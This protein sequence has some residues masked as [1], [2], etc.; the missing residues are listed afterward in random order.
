MK[1]NLSKKIISLLLVIMML[2]S[3]ISLMAYGVSIDKNDY[4]VV[5]VH[6]FMASS[7]V[8][9]KDDPNS[10]KYFPI[11]TKQIV[12]GVMLAVPALG[13][14]VLKQDWDA[15]G[16]AISPVLEKIFDGVYNNPDGSANGNSG[17]Y[18]EYPTEQEVKDS[19]IVKF[20]YDWRADP[21]DIASQLNDFVKYVKKASGK[22]KVYLSCHSLGGVIV[23]SYLSLYGNEDVSGVAFDATAIYGESYTGDLLTGKIDIESQSLLYSI[24]NSLRGSEVEEM[25]NSLLE[26]FE[27]AGLFKLVA[28]LGNEL[29]VRLRGY[30][31]EALAP[32]FASWLTIWAMVPDEMMDDAIDFVFGEI[33]DKNDKEASELLSKVENYNTLIRSHKTETLKELDKTANVVVISRYGFSSIPVTPSWNTLS[34]T[35]VDTKNNSFGATTAPYGESFS[36][37]YLK[38]KDMKYISPDKTVDASTCLFPDKTWFIRN[39]P[40][41]E[42]CDELDTM[43]Y[44]LLKSK[45]EAT[46][47]AYKEYPRFMQ[48]IAATESV[49]PDVESVELVALPD[50][51]VERLIKLFKSIVTLL[52]NTV[53]GL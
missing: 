39:I 12:S 11:D 20:S 16:E 47:D 9:D 37:E 2:L 23:L 29:A 13:K 6:G 17:H 33:Y 50:G 46:V 34:D 48:Y 8:A 3:T 32:L 42:T 26:V 15:F 51:F 21:V 4:P 22:D 41:A 38:D 49:C 25:V 31:Y 52:V 10:E 7:I 27:A 24:E 28:D 44:T 1:N 19:E 36:E 5:Y 18:F 53:A 14:L 43:I 45:K 40:H 35:V 30:I